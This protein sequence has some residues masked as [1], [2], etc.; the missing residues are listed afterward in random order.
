MVLSS[1]AKAN[2]ALSWR[3][4]R[5]LSFQRRRNLKGCHSV[6]LSCR[7]RRNLRAVIPSFCHV[8]CGGISS[9]PAP[10]FS[11]VYMTTRLCHPTNLISAS[12]WPSPSP[13]LVKHRLGNVGIVDWAL[14]SAVVW[15]LGCNSMFVN[16]FTGR[17]GRFNV[18]NA[19]FV[20]QD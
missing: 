3:R 14:V 6:I 5:K 4:A 11:A 16:V 20:I 8:D 18:N 2:I 19:H 15:A 1:S 13:A 9:A 17:G 10:D 12:S 7:L